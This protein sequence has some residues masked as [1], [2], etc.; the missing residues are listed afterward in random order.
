MCLLMFKHFDAC[1]RKVFTFHYGEKAGERGG[2]TWGA[3][4]LQV[5]PAAVQWE[6]KILC[7]IQE[8]PVRER[9]TS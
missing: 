1:L 9:E 3:H 8:S 6:L 7:V 5:E 4:K 2:G